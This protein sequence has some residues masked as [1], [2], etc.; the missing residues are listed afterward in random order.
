[1][2]SSAMNFA[3]RHCHNFD[4]AVMM[5]IR[6]AQKALEIQMSEEMPF[7]ETAFQACQFGV[8]NLLTSIFGIDRPCGHQSSRGATRRPRPRNTESVLEEDTQTSGQD[9]P[10]LTGEE[11]PKEDEAHIDY[12]KSLL[13]KVIKQATRRKKKDD[14][15][16]QLFVRT[17]CTRG[18]KYAPSFRIAVPKLILDQS[19][20]SPGKTEKQTQQNSANIIL[21]IKSRSV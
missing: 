19:Q 11:V 16:I 7:Y 20:M 15:D 1:M 17:N 13:V 5:S 4:R 3:K 8:T 9:G 12:F 18:H 6:T 2:I 21:I 10:R 14:N